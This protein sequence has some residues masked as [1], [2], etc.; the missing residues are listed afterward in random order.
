MQYLFFSG[1]CVKFKR[2]SEIQLTVF[3]WINVWKRILDELDGQ[4]HGGGGASSEDERMELWEF[5]FFIMRV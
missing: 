1:R 5:Q 2:T 4:A 3:E